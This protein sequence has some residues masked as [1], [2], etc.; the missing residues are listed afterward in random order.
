[1]NNYALQNADGYAVEFTS[2][3]EGDPP[4]GYVPIPADIDTSKLRDGLRYHVPTNTWMP[5][6]ALPNFVKWNIVRDQRNALLAQSDWTQLP[7]VPLATKEA[8]ATYRQALRDITD[9]SDP[10]NIVWPTPPA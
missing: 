4:E 6:P 7:D 2:F 3:S 10:F 5:R 8:W 9:Q 1:M